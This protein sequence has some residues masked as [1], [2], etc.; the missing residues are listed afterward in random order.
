VKDCGCV[1]KRSYIAGSGNVE[2]H[3]HAV[4][5]D[6]ACPCC[7]DWGR[8]DTNVRERER[9]QAWLANYLQ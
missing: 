6:K 3:Q 2:T 4:R 5:G 1:P 7:A 8:C 9:Y